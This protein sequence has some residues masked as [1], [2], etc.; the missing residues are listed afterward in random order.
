MYEIVY[1][2]DLLGIVIELF[3]FIVVFFGNDC[4]RLDK[5]GVCDYFIE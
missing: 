5:Y 2:I 4:N 1:S 3:V